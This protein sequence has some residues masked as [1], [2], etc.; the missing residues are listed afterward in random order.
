MTGNA[1]EVVSRR[2]RIALGAGQAHDVGLETASAYRGTVE[3]VLPQLIN[4]HITDPGLRASLRQLLADPTTVYELYTSTPEG[5]GEERPLSPSTDW[6]DII[7]RLQ[8]ADAELGLAR[9][10]QGGRVRR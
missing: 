8:D 2:L 3:S 9:A 10:H 5:E 4:E 1:Q 7:R 6:D